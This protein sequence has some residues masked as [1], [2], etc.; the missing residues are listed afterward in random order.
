MIMKNNTDE[1]MVNKLEELSKLNLGEDSR[2]MLSDDLKQMIDF[3]EFTES[4]PDSLP[5]DLTEVQCDR[6]CSDL[7]TDHTDENDPYD[8]LRA[9][10]LVKN[11]MYVVPKVIIHG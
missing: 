5:E 11:N 9:A 6:E 3:F 1:N 7:S 2:G 8:C 10:P 4:I